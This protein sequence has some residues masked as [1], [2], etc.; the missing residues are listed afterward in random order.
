MRE[1][2]EKIEEIGVGTVASVTGRYYAMD[3]DNRWERVKQAYD[4]SQKDKGKYFPHR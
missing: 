4:A 2:L 1:L 3:R